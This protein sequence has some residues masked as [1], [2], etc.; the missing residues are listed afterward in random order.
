MNKEDNAVPQ[1]NVPEP[2]SLEL[3]E[4]QILLDYNRRNA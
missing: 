2:L 4:Q 1:Q 3:N